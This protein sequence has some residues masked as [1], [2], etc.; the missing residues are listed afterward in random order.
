MPEETENYI[1]IPVIDSGKFVTKSFRT[2]S[3]SRDKGISAVIGK[4]KSAPSGSTKVQKYLFLKSKGWT[5]SKAKSW[6]KSHKGDD[7]MTDTKEAKSDTPVNLGAQVKGLVKFN[8]HI[9]KI[10]VLKAEVQ[11][12]GSTGHKKVIVSGEF[13]DDSVNKN[14]FRINKSTHESIAKQVDGMAAK[15]SHSYNDWEMVGTGISGEVVGNTVRYKV[16]VTAPKA[17][18]MFET[19]TWNEKNMGVSPSIDV[20][21]AEV[22]CSICGTNVMTDSCEHWPG[23]VY[24]KTKDKKGKVCYF[25]VSGD[26]PLVEGSFTSIPAYGPDSGTVDEV[27]FAASIM[28]IIKPSTLKSA[29]NEQED[30]LETKK[31]GQ[32]PTEDGS[33]EGNEAIDSLVAKSEEVTKLQA[34]VTEQAEKIAEF[35]QSDAKKT[36]AELTETKA[37][38]KEASEKLKEKT[39]LLAETEIKLEVYTKA[40]RE[41]E[42]TKVIDNKEVVASVIEKKLSDVD[43]EAEV[44]KLKKVKATF[45]KQVG[46]APVD[47]A[48]ASQEGVFDTKNYLASMGIKDPFASAN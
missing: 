21:N 37:S 29:L 15:V 33:M 48:D 6:V 2:I 12:D 38:L 16:A 40:A 22:I 35:E 27:T 9:S 13:F 18:E 20:R 17:V 30:D 23:R 10:E 31:S 34:K 14:F 28:K 44:A 32:E 5:M 39:D 41:A 8:T 46:S 11:E 1:H 24:G 4:L 42:L 26:V 19:G 3:I 43:F 45:E 47:S 36:E 25:D 7:E